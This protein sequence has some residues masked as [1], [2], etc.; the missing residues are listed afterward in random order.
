[1]GVA[2]LVGVSAYAA[3]FTWAGLVTSRPL[4]FA[5][6]Y[7]FLWEGVINSFINGVSYLSVRGYTLGIMYGINATEFQAL[8]E[9]AIE[10]PA[11]IVGAAAVTLVF[12]LL[13]IR[14]LRRMDVP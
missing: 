8:S 3:I 7:V 13:G 2:T 5:L 14:R 6:L 4:V 1:M 12:L 10:F 9:R 11:A